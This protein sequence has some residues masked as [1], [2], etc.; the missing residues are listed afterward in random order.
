MAGGKGTRLGEITQR[1]PKPLISINGTP[2]L[3]RIFDAFPEEIT[4]VI[5]SVAHLGD[6]IS[7]YTGSLFKNRSVTHVQCNE[8]LMG[9][10]G[11]VWAA[12]DLIQNGERFL[13][14]S[15]D[16]IYQRADLEACLKNDL[17]FGLFQELPPSEKFFSIE[18]NGKGDVVRF[19]RPQNLEE[20]INIAT[21]VYVLDDRIFGYDPV[22]LK[23]AEYGLPQTIL[24]MAQDIPVRGVVMDSWLPI[25]TP[26]DIQKA[27][28]ML[29][30]K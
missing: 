11:A 7:T 25:N 17:A 14:V 13:V 16:D 23:D 18:L 2:I 6:Q 3:D 1:I 15:G 8:A 20:K 28:N 27:K 26:E 12:R 4:E 19:V 22:H 21:G 9:T 10:A 24:R 29:N 5:I 30:S